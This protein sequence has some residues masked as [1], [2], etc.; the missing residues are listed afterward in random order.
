MEV[1]AAC[2]LWSRSEARGLRYTG[3]L[4]DGDSKA[5]NVV[6]KFDVYDVPIVKEECK[7]CSQKN[8]YCIEQSHQTEKVRGVP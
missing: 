1:E 4:S 8:G 2:I 5:Y 6:V 7:P 3:F